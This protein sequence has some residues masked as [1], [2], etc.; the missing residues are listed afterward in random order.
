VSLV[1]CEPKIVFT[2]G[3]RQ[4][5]VVL[6]RDTQPEGTL[7]Q[8]LPPFFEEAFSGGTCAPCSAGVCL[9]SSSKIS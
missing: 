2:V 5:Y 1:H 4:G 9:S 3:T 7:P 8:R 6:L